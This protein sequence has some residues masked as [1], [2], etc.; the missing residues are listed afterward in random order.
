MKS[1]LFKLSFVLLL[2]T[3]LSSC[4]ED[5]INYKGITGT[6]ENLPLLTGNYEYAAWILENGNTRLMGPITINADGEGIFSFAPISDNIADATS[7]L[8]TIEDNSVAYNS[9]SETQVLDCNF[10]TSDQAILTANAIGSDFGGI[11]GNY[12]LS[13]PTTSSSSTD[14]S[15]IWYVTQDINQGLQLPVLAAGWKYEGW[16]MFNNIPVSTGK[17]TDAGSLDESNIYG[18]SEDPFPY[19]GEDFNNPAVAPTGVNFPQDLKGKVTKITLEPFPD[20]SSDPYNM[21][22]LIDT[23]SNPSVTNINYKL[24]TSLENLPSGSVTKEVE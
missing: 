22:I 9:P 14:N 6:F 19:P 20:N 8:I 16:V 1:I 7:I 5:K 11:S 21:V 23:I 18:G 12:I 15:G 13:S 3:F 17:F 24:N 2:I 10:G 4:G